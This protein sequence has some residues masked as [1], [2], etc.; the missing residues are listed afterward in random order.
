MKSRSMVADVAE[1]LSAAMPRWRQVAAISAG[2]S[3]QAPDGQVFMR[4]MVVQRK[5]Q[6]PVQFELTQPTRF[7][8][9]AWI[10]RANLKP[11][12]YLFVVVK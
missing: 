8:V 4:A 9:T 3:T 2:Q 12:H 10:E 1:G 5:V 6:R 7:A 11:E